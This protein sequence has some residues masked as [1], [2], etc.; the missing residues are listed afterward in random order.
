M[1]KKE[2]VKDPDKIKKRDNI[3]TII[4]SIC[5]VVAVVV[6]FL[7]Y[8]PFNGFR[9]WL[10]T[11]AMSTMNHQYFATT[12]Y[13]DEYINKV[14]ARHSIKEP[15]GNTDISAIIG[16]EENYID[17]YDKEIKNVEK[18]YKKIVKN[19]LNQIPKKDCVQ[20]YKE[21]ID[22]YLQNSNEVMQYLKE[23]TLSNLKKNEVSFEDLAPIMYIQFKVFGIK[24][25]CKIKHVVIDEAQDYGEFQFDVLKTILN[26]NSMTILG[27]IAQGV[28]YYRGIENWKRFID[29]EF[30]NVKTVYTTLNKTYRTTKEIMDIANI[31]INKLPEYEKEYIVLGDP[32]IDRKNSISIKKVESKKDLIESINEKI[33]EHLD[34][35][36]KS[37][38]IIGKDMKECEMI[39]REICKLRSDVK[40]I[41][42]KDSE[43]NSGISVVP[44]YLA[45]G[46]EFDCVII[47]NANNVKYTN[48]SLDI[49][50]LY[51]T[52]TR[53]MSKLDILYDG[54]MTDLIGKRI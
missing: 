13:S 8:G 48:T 49:K 37:I 31:V 52:I 9:D 51:V 6:L 28:H 20:Y 43:Y 17:E 19:Y 15:D 46:L 47:S 50:L 32:V 2:R 4:L 53:A 14:L 25:K 41:R 38:A 40:L 45:K 22:S 54:E 23:N 34:N 7:L 33:N 21:F 26:S 39:E 3:F 36:Y 12:F 30:N 24:D 27:D 1:K 42:G 44:S 35:A 16:K 11:T 5:D 29:V 10:V 18:G